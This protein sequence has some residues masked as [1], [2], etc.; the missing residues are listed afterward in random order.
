MRRCVR[1]PPPTWTTFRQF[2]TGRMLSNFGKLRICASRA[3]EGFLPGTERGRNL[4]MIPDYF[5]SCIVS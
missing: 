5:V 4:R 2:P 3:F 1:I